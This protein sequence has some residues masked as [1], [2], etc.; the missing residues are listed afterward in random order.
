VDA[1]RSSPIRPEWRIYAAGL[2]NSRVPLPRRLLIMTT[3]RAGSELLV[4]LLNAHPNIVCTG[5]LALG[6]GQLPRLNPALFVRGVAIASMKGAIRSGKEASVFGWK[7]PSNHMRWH[8]ARFPSPVDFIKESISPDGLL[9]VL[10]RR[11]FVAQALSWQ[12]AEQTKYHFTE[13]ETFERIAV[14]PEG[15]LSQTFDYELEDR[16]LAETTRGLPR[17]EV[18]YEDDLLEPESQQKTLDL[19]TGALGLDPCP[20]T[21]HL[22]RITP[23]EPSERIANLEEVRRVFQATRFSGLLDP[24]VK[25]VLGQQVPAKPSAPLNNAR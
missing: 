15:L 25:E 21:T 16:W 6:P 19:I 10:R 8:P 4:S 20:V 24:E 13:M 1:V 23:A 2:L 7:L 22:N 14:D 3:G 11:N 12:H 9:V 18:T 17:V 5:E